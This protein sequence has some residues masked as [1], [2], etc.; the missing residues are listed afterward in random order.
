MIMPLQ[1]SAP[2][3]TFC[4]GISFPSS[5]FVL[6][7]TISTIIMS[8]Q[9]VDGFASSTVHDDWHVQP[10]LKKAFPHMINY[11]SAKTIAQANAEG[12]RLVL[13]LHEDETPD[14]K[15]QP[16]DHEVFLKRAI[17]SDYIGTKKDWPD[18]RRTLLYMRTEIRFYQEIAPNLRE[19]GFHAIPRVYLAQHSLEEW[20]PD[21]E[22]GI[23]SPGPPPEIYQKFAETKD[24]SV[25]TG[26]GE[27]VM[28]CVK[29]NEY[30]Q[31]SPVTLQQ[32]KQCLTAVA[33]LHGTAWQDS[34][35]L[36]RCIDRLTRGSYHL[37][38]R[39][40]KELAEME[41]A[42]KHFS[43]QFVE[44]LQKAGLT[45]R[46]KDLGTRLK[47]A[48]PAISEIL[49]PGPTDPYATLVHGDFKA[50]NVFLP[51]NNELTPLL[52]DYQST[53]VGVGMSDV[54]YIHHGVLPNQLADGGEEELVDHYLNEL[55]RNLPEGK[56]YP[57][58]IAIKHYRMAVIDYGRF[59]LG[60]FWKTATPEAF[61]KKKDSP[62]TT[63]INRDVDA[64]MAFI[65]RL[66][67]YLAEFEQE[68]EH[69][70]GKGSS[71]S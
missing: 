10:T 4:T 59:I 51:L 48:A 67:R 62:N 57:R 19:R 40:P 66:E 64:A 49:S 30:M 20:M 2:L 55:G 14:H 5:I 44:P 35:L 36:S 8:S 22:S 46:T 68:Q 13:T 61:E 60:R 17:V 50:M 25:A 16:Y 27:I 12:Q 63:L 9:P 65:D 23:A 56:T 15:P 42:W 28:D 7:I 69:G 6:A 47:K 37:Q 45:E 33:Q 52:V 26:S 18:L 1:S 21:S 29:D 41:A 58:E 70:N 53:G 11:E 54:A 39:N 3:E 32:S 43:T 31:T 38:L 71:E 24:P 34:E